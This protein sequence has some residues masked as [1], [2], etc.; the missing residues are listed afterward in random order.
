ML[1]YAYAFKRHAMNKNGWMA[2]WYRAYLTRNELRW[3]A[4]FKLRSIY[5]RG[6][7]P[8]HVSER[9]LAG[10]QGRSEYVPFP[11]L[12]PCNRPAPT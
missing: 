5:S 9:K 11:E 1:S 7:R 6:T 10:P 4:S 12:Q 8:R 2:T 3:V